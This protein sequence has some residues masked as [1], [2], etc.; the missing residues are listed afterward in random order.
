MLY[1]GGARP[2]RGFT[3]SHTEKTFLHKPHLSQAAEDAAEPREQFTLR[4]VEDR[5]F[6][7]PWFEDKHLAT[8]YA[9]LL[10]FHDACR[11]VALRLVQAIE[12]GLGVQRDSD[13]AL[14]PRHL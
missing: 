2:A 6:P 14:P 10:S 7:T 3:P 9:T 12:L 1:L 4:P 5:E 11:L 8:C 13:R